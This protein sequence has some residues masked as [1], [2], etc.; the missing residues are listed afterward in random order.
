MELRGVLEA[1]APVPY[2]SCF[3]AHISAISSKTRIENTKEKYNFKMVSKVCVPASDHTWFGL[4]WS[5]CGENT[6]YTP[7]WLYPSFCILQRLLS[8][9]FFCSPRRKWVT[10]CICLAFVFLHIVLPSPPLLSLSF[11]VKLNEKCIA[12]ASRS[13]YFRGLS[14]RW[15][16]ICTW[17]E[18]LWDVAHLHWFDLFWQGF[19]MGRWIF[20]HSVC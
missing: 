4:V 15:F 3:L 16:I 13:A 8:F 7:F 2:V 18:W 9:Y 20:E 14:L 5:T 11:S 1:S 6:C 19:D 10:L 17:A 12:L